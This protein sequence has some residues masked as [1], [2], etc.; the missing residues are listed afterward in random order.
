MARSSEAP[1]ICSK[2]KAGNLGL[3]NSMSSWLSSSMFRI[4]AAKSSSDSSAS[5]K[6]SCSSSCFSKI[7][8][9]FSSSFASASLP[10]RFSN[11]ACLFR[12][13]T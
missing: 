13:L 5:P 12:A 11:R 1:R 6:I 9:F 2:F 10:S 7:L 4:I 8:A 3:S